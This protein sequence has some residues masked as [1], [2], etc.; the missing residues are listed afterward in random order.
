M[1]GIREDV[2]ELEENMQSVFLEMLLTIDQYDLYGKVAYPKG[3]DAEEIGTIYRLAA[4]SQGVFVNPAL[5]EPFGLTLIE[6]AASGLPVV[7]TRD[8]G[9]VDI[10]KNC[11]NGYLIDPLDAKGIADT[12]LELLNDPERWQRFSQT[13][14]ELVK[15]YYT[16]ESHVESYLQMIQPIVDK[17]ESLQRPILQRRP[18]L[19][20][21]GAIVSSLDQNLLGDPIS[22][23]QLMAYLKTNKNNIAFCIATGRDFNSA[24]KVLR[25]NQILQ[26]DA[27]IT[28]MGT[29]I[30]YSSAL[31]K[32]E[33]WTNHI[34]YLWNRSRVVALLSN[35]P[36][37]TLQSKKE[38]SLYKISYF[39]D[40]NFAPRVDEIKR[41]L[42]QNEQTVNTI[43]SFG[44]FL[45][46]VPIRAS[47]GYA[48]RWFSQQQDIPLERILTAGGSGGDE[49]MMLGNTLSVVVA[50]RHTEELADIAAIEPLYF[51]EK[52]FA[53]GI[54]DGLEHYD[55]LRRCEIN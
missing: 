20:Y 46:I 24:L 8:G 36:G 51:S 39:Y 15:R 37:L 16:W 31:I 2:H 22:L 30:Y 47:K 52:Q 14:N 42:L 29:E 23:Q 10:L 45:D 33:A 43:M 6:A 7:A 5:T 50:N 21:S 9:P 1:A 53:A 34:N 35:L 41:L 17:T 55:F 28:N 25:Q 4:L 11:R 26:P 12:L 44:Q 54:L 3:F 38:Q 19:F 27:L 48:V 32:D 49:D 40:A 13:G 18:M